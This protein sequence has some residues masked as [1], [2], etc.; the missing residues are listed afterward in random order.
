M[1]TFGDSR[2]HVG[3]QIADLLCSALIFPMATHAYCLNHVYNIHVD[4]GFG[5]LTE[6]DGA[7]LRALQYRYLVGDRYRGG[8]TVDDR[9]GQRPGGPLFRAATG[10]GQADS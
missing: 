1:P 4:P 8:L 7:R 10:V 6:R 2:N 3:I 9:V 5:D